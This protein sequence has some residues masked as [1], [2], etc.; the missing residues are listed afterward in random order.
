MAYLHVLR[1]IIIRYKQINQK[2][3]LVSI[4]TLTYVVR[5]TGITKKKLLCN[6]LTLRGI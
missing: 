1:I 6:W 3:N 5:N 2:S 4:C